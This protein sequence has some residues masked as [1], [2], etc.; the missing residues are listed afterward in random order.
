MSFGPVQQYS[1]Q[2][3]Y[4]AH[5]RLL[6]ALQ[7]EGWRTDWLIWLGRCALCA[8]LSCRHSVCVPQA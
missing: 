6:L 8:V 4:L 7:S 2:L 3:G 1:G 5:L